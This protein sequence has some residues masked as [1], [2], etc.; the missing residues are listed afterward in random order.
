MKHLAQIFLERKMFQRKV[1]QKI[2]IPVLGSVSFFK[3]WRRLRDNV[4][5]YGRAR[6]ATDEV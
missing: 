4:G 1:V 5:K 6:Q 3:K 2:K